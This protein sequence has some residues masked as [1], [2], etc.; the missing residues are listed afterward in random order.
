MG[1]SRAQKQ[2]EIETLNAR[3][4]EHETIVVT[5][6][7]GL[8]VSELSEL[9]AEARKEGVTIKV[10]KN[11]LAK[12]ALKGTKF[13]GAADLFSGPTAVA[14]SVDVVAPAKVI[15][16]FAKDN[17]KLIIVGGAMGAEVLD[18]KGVEA[19]SKMPSL[20]D[21]RATIAGIIMAPASKIASAVAAPGSK[22]AGAVKAA[23]EK[24]D[25]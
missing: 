16:K 4:E 21:V 6:Y 13:E 11:T 18:A 8:T 23:G 14:S 15:Q 5:H 3:F 25:A 17:D 24:A 12:L 10:T 7:S 20:D 2:T 9:R 19:L 1:M 22:V